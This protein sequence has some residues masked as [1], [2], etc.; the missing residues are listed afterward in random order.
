MSLNACTDRGPTA[1]TSPDPPPA[2][3]ARI[4]SNITVSN[5]VAATAQKRPPAGF[6]DVSPD[7][8][9][10][11]LARRDLSHA[12][13][14]GAD[15][16][17]TDL[18]QA[19]LESANL[20]GA[21]LSGANLSQSRLDSADL[22]RAIWIDGSLCADSSMGECEP[23]PESIRL[24]DAAMRKLPDPASFELV[25]EDQTVFTVRALK[26]YNGHAAAVSITYDSAYGT[27][28]VHA[29]TAK[30]VAG[31][32]LRMDHEMVTS[33]YQE[34]RWNPLL[35]R[36]RQE[37]LPNDIHLFGHG[38]EH[39]E[40]DTMSYADAYANFKRCYDLMEE[41]GL[42]PKAYAYPHSSGKKVSTQAA[43]RAAGFICARG[44]TLDLEEV[45]LCS[46]DAMEP[47]NWY[48]LPAVSMAEQFEGYV[49]NHAELAPV[50]DRTLD[51]TAWVI[52]MYHAIGQP[53]GW[54]YYDLQEFGRDLTQI[55]EGD[56]WSANMDAAAAYIKERKGLRL[57]LESVSSAGDLAVQ[58]RDGLDNEVYDQPL[59]FEFE[60]NPDLHIQLV[61][62]VPPIDQVNTFEVSNNR[63][64]LNILPDEAAHSLRFE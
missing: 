1:P 27:W 21:D 7:C 49:N 12:D 16:R 36:I 53:L 57:E 20:R 44:S 19:N 32:G 18:S 4:T 5:A 48:Y 2:P 41:W 35:P 25:A 64:R 37:L 63:L 59:T 61:H 52:L 33:F 62:V 58:F 30:L 3:A 56:F 9:G 39:L 28:N 50:L 6:P 14:S 13:L 40:H 22:G 11:Y 54:G 43:N 31:K 55:A 51:E 45:Y 34:A 29:M 17:G 38:H 26:W 46:G 23:I 24:S 8:P 42:N 15:L 10:C 47:R 60:F